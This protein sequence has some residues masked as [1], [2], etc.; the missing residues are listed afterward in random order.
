[1]K[2]MRKLDLEELEKVTGGALPAGVHLQGAESGKY[3]ESER[4]HEGS[5]QQKPDA[6]SLYEDIG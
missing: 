2:D 4:Y 5:C 6:S 3:C 1:M